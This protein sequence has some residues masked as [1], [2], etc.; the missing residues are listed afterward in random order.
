MTKS[1]ELSRLFAAER[2]Q[3]PEAMATQRAW[4][5]LRGSLRSGAPS[6]TIASGPLKL[7]L[8]LATKSFIGSSLLAFVVTTAGLGIHAATTTVAP[9]AER[10][11]APPSA[12]QPPQQASMPRP[13]LAVPV[14]ST[15]SDAR[16]APR[17]PNA[18]DSSTLRD[19]LELL[20]AAKRE[21]D[22]GRPHL[23]AVW[24]DQHEARYPKGVLRQ[25][26]QR[27]RHLLG[28]QAREGR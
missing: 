3:A 21:L 27:L 18:S 10:A 12:S 15:S 6:L 2:A 1:D 9:S 7:G 19:E 17:S 5:G 25:E 16:S 28:Q 24:L 4:E 20:K 13:L 11:A 14:P 8:S 22:Q 23:A 26:R